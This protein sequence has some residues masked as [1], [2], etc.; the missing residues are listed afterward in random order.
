MIKAITVLLKKQGTGKAT[1]VHALTSKSLSVFIKSLPK[2]QQRWVKA[3]GFAAKAGSHL[4]I[5]DE[6]G[7]LAHVLYGLDEAAAAEAFA[8]CKLA[9]QL[10]AGIYK[11]ADGF[12][13]PFLVCL[14]W[15]LQQY[16]FTRYLGGVSKPSNELVCLACPD[17]VDH[18]R[19]CAQADAI[20]MGRDLINTPAEDMGPSELEASARDLAR[21]HKAK[22]T[23]IKGAALKKGFPLID[24]VGRASDD[25][26]RLLDMTWGPARAPKVTLV[27][28]GVCF[29]TGGL[30]LKPSA[31]M[32]LMKKDMGGAAAVLTLAAM[33]MSARLNVGLRVLVPAVENAVAGNAFRPGDILISRKGLSVEIGNTDAEGRLVLADALDLAD[34]EKPELLIDMATLTGAARVALGPD[35]PPFYTDDEK[36]AGELSFCSM[37]VNDPVWRLPFW[38]RYNDMFSSPIADINNAGSG[39][40][41]GSITAALF[42]KRF[43]TNTKSYVHLDIYGWVP[44]ARPA[45]PAGGEP[46]AVRALF[47]LIEAR[48]PANE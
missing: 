31:G 14:G 9:T 19:V 33:I 10:P 42:L 11:L 46:N 44:S 45:R 37:A 13:D 40:F 26:P 21:S 18:A 30:D 29:D 27:G 48:Y 3:N 15:V 36:L 17:S 2:G 38:A 24:A 25:A 41:A 7:N 39:G 43:V 20:M 1:P 23:V 34:S 22:F 8:P 4:C 12:P 6:D 32:L 28:K 35:L 47:D 5:P 16:K